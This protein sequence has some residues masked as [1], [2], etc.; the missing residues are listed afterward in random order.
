MSR[1]KG[2][3][4]YQLSEPWETAIAGWLSWL[5]LSGHSPNTIRLRREHMRSVA[6]MLHTAHPRDVTF[7]DL[8]QLCSARQWGNEYR[9]G[10]RTSLVS[11]YEWC[12]AN[13][14]A[15]ENPAARLS[16]VRGENPKSRPAGDDVWEDL[17]AKAQPRELMM[18]RLAGEAGMRRAEVAQCHRRD[19]IEDPRGCSLIVHGKGNKQRVVPISDSLAQAIRAH[20]TAGYLFPGRSIGDHMSPAWV[21]TMISQ[22]MPEGFTIHTLRHRFGTRAYRGSHNLRAVQMLLSHASVATTERYTAVDDDEIRAAMMSAMGT[23]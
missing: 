13:A 20:C 19:L 23:E 8:V 16:K 5:H 3:G 10:V 1:P 17:I 7:A 12:I 15:Q 18:I 2:S 22:L 6:R 11:F 4:R 21:G 9:K 14:V